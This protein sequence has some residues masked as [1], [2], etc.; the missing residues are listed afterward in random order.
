LMLHG[1]GSEEHHMKVF[2]VTGG[3]LAT[4]LLTSQAYAFDQA[5][6][7]QACGNDVFSICQQAM[8]DHNRI[9]ACLRQHFKQVSPSCKQFMANYG[10][11]ERQVRHNGRVETTGTAARD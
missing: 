10:K 4:V 8:P 5:A 6:A 11:E 2:W 7:Q 3:V 9:A 1:V